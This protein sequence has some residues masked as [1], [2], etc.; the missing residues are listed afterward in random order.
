M[1]E[2]I[3]TGAKLYPILDAEKAVIE[4]MLEYGKAIEGTCVV[5]GYAG[6]VSTFK[7]RVEQV[8]SDYQVDARD[9]FVE[10]GK[11]GAI[12]GQDDLI[13]EVAQMLSREKY[14][15]R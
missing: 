5:S 11:R 2:G 13:L 14:R 15:G 8:A 7:N 6:V 3:Q 12:A 9:I 4:G 10:L 1:K